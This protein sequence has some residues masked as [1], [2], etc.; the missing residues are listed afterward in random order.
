MGIV[1]RLSDTRC[2]AYSDDAKAFVREYSQIKVVKLLSTDNNQTSECQLQARAIIDN[3]RLL[4]TGI[5]EVLWNALLA[6]FNS[7]SC[8]IQP[9][10]W[11]QIKLLN[12][13]NL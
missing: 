11:I 3:M 12:S 9:L 2:S 6:R 10:K 7:I 5:L 4:E 1:K 13:S 8:T